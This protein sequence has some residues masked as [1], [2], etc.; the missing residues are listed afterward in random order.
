MKNCVHCGLRFQPRS[1]RQR[2]CSIICRTANQAGLRASL[3]GREHRALR[4][5]LEP[6]VAAGGARCA[7]CGSPIERGEPWAL[8][9]LPHGGEAP[10]HRDC[11]AAAGART[12]FGDPLRG[13]R[14]EEPPLR[15][16][17]V[18]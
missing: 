9:H 4:R 10:S 3:Y 5:A 7:R 2:F 14:V 6:M 8:D 16:S 12:S 18:W 15:T 1:N 17:R 13:G 11:N